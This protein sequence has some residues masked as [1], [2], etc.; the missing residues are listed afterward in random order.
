MNHKTEHD[1]LTKT[2]REFQDKF[3]RNEVGL[4]IDVMEFLKNWLSKQILGSDQR[5]APFL[6]AQGVH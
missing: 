3:Q 4:T 5:Y 1:R 6:N 2:V